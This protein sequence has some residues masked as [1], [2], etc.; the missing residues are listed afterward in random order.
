M[1]FGVIDLIAVLTGPT[2]TGQ[3]PTE[4]SHLRWNLH[5]SAELSP[6]RHAS[7]KMYT[8]M[9]HDGAGSLRS[10]TW[11]NGFQLSKRTQKN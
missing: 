7:S 1:C 4:V 9:V 6:F 11:Q 2:K 10:T 3:G 5:Y 8:W